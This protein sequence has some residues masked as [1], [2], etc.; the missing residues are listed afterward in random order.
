MI[1]TGAAGLEVWC[2]MVTGGYAGVRIENMTE[3]WRN[4]LVFCAIIHRFRPAMIDYHLLLPGQVIRNSELAFSI[5]EKILGHILCWI[6]RTC[7]RATSWT[8]SPS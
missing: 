1:V 6:P 7:Y 5:A 8:S 3:S 2:R 4:G